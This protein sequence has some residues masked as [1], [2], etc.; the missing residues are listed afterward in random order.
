MAKGRLKTLLSASQDVSEISL[1]WT[2]CQYS[3][4]VKSQSGKDILLKNELG[5]K[6]AMGTAKRTTTDEF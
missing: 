2:K 3:F 6:R 4:L 1:K 5:F